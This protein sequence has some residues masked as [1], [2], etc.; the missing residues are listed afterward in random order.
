[1][2]TYMLAF[3]C[4]IQVMSEITRPY[5]AHS[6]LLKIVRGKAEIMISRT[7]ASGFPRARWYQA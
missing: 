6:R 3:K 5:Q 2:C 1:M 4:K 7:T